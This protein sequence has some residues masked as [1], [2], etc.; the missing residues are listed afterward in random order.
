MVFFDEMTRSTYS[1]SLGLAAQQKVT[2]LSRT[3]SFEPLIGK[4][5]YFDNYGDLEMDEYTGRGSD[6]ILDEMPRF[7]RLI[8]RRKFRKQILLDK[9]DNSQLADFFEPGAQFFN[10]LMAAAARK[11]D[12]VIVEALDAAAPGGEEGGTTTALPAGQKLNDTGGVLLTTTTCTEAKEL[13]DQADVD[14]DN[15]F[16]VKDPSQL[17]Q[18][19]IGTTLPVSNFDYNTVRALVRGEIDTWLG[20]TFITTNRIAQNG[21][22][23]RYAFFYHMNAMVYGVESAADIR[24]SP[25]PDKNDGT[26]VSVYL[27]CAATRRYENQMVRTNQTA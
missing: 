13:L 6:S 19:L 9:D 4:K 18:L 22:A 21:T 2:K 12:L 26:Q 1:A 25:R 5:R 8:T 3:A 10:V 23:Q 11:I 24:V 14:P 20:F 16:A 15:R 17:Q 7:R 27:N